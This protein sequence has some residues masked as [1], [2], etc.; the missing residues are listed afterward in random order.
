MSDLFPETEEG[1]IK[2]FTRKI[3]EDDV[4]EHGQ[5]GNTRVAELGT[6]YEEADDPLCPVIK[7]LRQLLKVGKTM[8]SHVC[9]RAQAHVHTPLHISKIVD[10]F[11]GVDIFDPWFLKY[12]ETPTI[13]K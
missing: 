8:L 11:I 12:A 7:N 1:F 9:F 6:D 3:N 13:T 4:S 10:F 5:L 2:I